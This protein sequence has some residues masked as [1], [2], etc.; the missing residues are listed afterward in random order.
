MQYLGRIRFERACVLLRDTDLPI[1][2]IGFTCGYSNSQ[3]FAETFKR[4]AR[5]TPSEYRASLMDFEVIMKSNW[6]HPEMRSIE[7]ELK[8]KK[9]MGHGQLRYRGWMSQIYH[10]INRNIEQ[11]Y[12]LFSSRAL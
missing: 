4:F 8:R 7:D 10:P 2:E 11:G 3:Y 9:A 6:R 5:I 12:F 1:A